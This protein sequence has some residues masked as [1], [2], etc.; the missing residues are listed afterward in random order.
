[1]TACKDVEAQ[2]IRTAVPV[3]F[4]RWLALTTAWPFAAIST[5][6]I[7]AV[8]SLAAEFNGHRFSKKRQADIAPRDPPGQSLK[9]V[10]KRSIPFHLQH[11][12]E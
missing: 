10:E 4:S 2:K 1:V 6:K 8:W 12:R 9:D 7:I 5:T 11:C 3:S